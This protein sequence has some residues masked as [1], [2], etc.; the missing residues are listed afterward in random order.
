MS[1]YTLQSWATRF[2]KDHRFKIS[3]EIEKNLSQKQNAKNKYG[4]TPIYD[5]TQPKEVSGLFKPPY[6]Q[7]PLNQ[8]R[9]NT[10]NI[11]NFLIKHGAKVSKAQSAWVVFKIL[12]AWMN[13]L[14]TPNI[15]TLSPLL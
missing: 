10:V 9:E 2:I 3:V 5:A 13:I 12:F 4:T 11:V 6:R 8:A 14:N 7:K 1:Y 15:E